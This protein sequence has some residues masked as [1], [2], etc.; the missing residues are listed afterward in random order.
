MSIDGTFLLLIWT[1]SFIG[2]SNA[3][4]PV[5]SNL[6]NTHTIADT[7]SVTTSIYALT[8]TDADGDALTYSMTV[9]SAYFDLSGH[10]R[11]TGAV[12]ADAYALTFRVIDT[13]GGI[14]TGTL[15]VTVTNSAP[16]LTNTVWTASAAES[17][18]DE[19]Q[20]FLI[21]YTDAS[22]A[23]YVDCVVQSST[24]I[25]SDFFVRYDSVNSKYAVY[26]QQNPTLTA[27][28]YS[29]VIVCTDLSSASD[30]GTLIVTVVQNAAPVFQ[31]PGGT[32]TIASSSTSIGTTVHTVTA[33][34]TD[35]QQLFYNMTTNPGGAPFQIQ[36]SGDILL[37]QSILGLTIATYTLHVFVYDGYNLVGPD[38]VTIS[39]SGINNAPTIDNLP[40][41]ASVAENTAAATSIFQ[42][43]T[44]EPDAGQTLTYTAFSTPG[45]VMSYLSLNS[46]TGLLSTSSTNINFETVGVTTVTVS[47]IVSDGTA[48]VT[49]DLALTI[50][51]VNEAPS[52]QKSQYTSSGSEG[53]AGSSFSNP[54]FVINDEDTSDSL[55]TSIDCASTFTMNP[56][57]G[58]LTLT[59][60]YDVDTGSGTTVTCTVTVTDSL[61]TDTSTLTVTINNINDNTPTFNPSVYTWYTDST[62]TIGT[63]VGT[64]TATDGDIGDFGT[65]SYSLDN[66]ADAAY[67]GVTNQGVVYVK[68]SI[69]SLGTGGSTLAFIVTATDTGSLAGNAAVQI[70]IPATT[71]TS[72][73]TTTDRHMSFD[74]SAS[75]VAWLTTFCGVGLLLAGLLVFMAYKNGFFTWIVDALDRMCELCRRKKSWDLPEE[76]EYEEES[77]EEEEEY[78]YTP[79]PRQQ[80]V[81]T[82]G[83]YGWNPWKQDNAY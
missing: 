51:D 22:A 11:A 75:N 71:T 56:T 47:V 10:V 63:S 32:V 83:E 45:S 29:L 59:A 55:T 79:P 6:D 37:T 60:P 12:P 42:V 53:L 35:S 54:N 76:E 25:S 36:H 80:Q 43:S 40:G 62:S 66:S 78:A 26:A 34:D 52:F 61:L 44:T 58:A 31:N 33:T 74:E 13:S 30:T 82:I 17:E 4:V 28:S 2:F 50:T 70:I 9:S 27:A 57:S 64:V 48:T 7:F 73:T 67:L 23:D 41:T 3:A 69:E 68:S 1:N 49:S 18:T 21:E 14:A 24:P 5:F 16:T 8:A 38:T 65:I 46:A 15:T 72:T 77:E 39:V 20:L 81:A 19:T